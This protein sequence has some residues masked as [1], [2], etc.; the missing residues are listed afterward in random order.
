MPTASIRQ[1]LAFKLFDQT[2]HSLTFA[3]R[4]HT[5]IVVIKLHIRVCLMGK[6]K[7]Q[8]DK[9]RSYD[10]IKRRFPDSTVSFDCFV[11]HVP[12]LD[13][14]FVMPHD[15]IYMVLHTLNQNIPTYRL[16]FLVLEKPFWC[17]R[18]PYQAMPVTT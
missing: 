8:T 10:L 9:V 11:D 2:H 18:M 1:P 7:S 15:L 4:V 14:A 12:T 6:L 5:V 3:R 13:T 16:S 17:L